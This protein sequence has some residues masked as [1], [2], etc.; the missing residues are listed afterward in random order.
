MRIIVQT[1]QPQEQAERWFYTITLES[2]A[3]WRIGNCAQFFN[4]DHCLGSG[5]DPST[6]TGKCFPCRGSGLFKFE[7]PCAGHHSPEEA[8]EHQSIWV[9]DHTLWM[10]FAETDAEH[11][12]VHP[13]R[14]YA[15]PSPAVGYYTLPAPH[16][17]ERR[18]SCEAHQNLGALKRILH[19]DLVHSR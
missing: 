15:C 9:L 4:C 13:E 2:G 6:S 8:I 11:L 10:P 12:S 19:L 14:C 7:R 1:F 5:K 17:G 16:L 18:Y 3:V